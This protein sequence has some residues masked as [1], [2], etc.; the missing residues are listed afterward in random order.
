MDLRRRKR[1]FLPWQYDSQ[2]KDAMEAFDVRDY[3]KRSLFDSYY[4]L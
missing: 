4:N 1:S 3:K 2:Y